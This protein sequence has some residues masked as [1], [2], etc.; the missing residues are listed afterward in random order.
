MA[1]Y[2]Q[3]QY[4]QI[5]RQKA[6]AWAKYY[7]S[8]SRR[9]DDA[10]GI[11]N[12]LQASGFERNHGE[13]IKPDIIPP[14]ITSVFIEMAELLNREYTCPVCFDLVNS[15][16]IHLTWCGH[17]LCKPCYEQLSNSTREEKPSCP[18]CRKKI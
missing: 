11:V 1:T 14:H 8:V 13:L 7:E 18:T 2:S 16:T 9:A 5:K 15:G 6:F 4:N 17:I 3:N 10:T 12:M